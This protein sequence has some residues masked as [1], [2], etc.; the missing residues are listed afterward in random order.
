M[1]RESFRNESGQDNFKGHMAKDGSSHLCQIIMNVV[2]T[3]ALNNPVTVSYTRL[4]IKEGKHWRV[5]Q[6]HVC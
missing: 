6:T 5:A 1:K 4:S 3:F 2:D